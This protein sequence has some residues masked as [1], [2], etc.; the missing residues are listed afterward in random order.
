MQRARWRCLDS[1]EIES[2]GSS[3][4]L[5]A[6]LIDGV[7]IGEHCSVVALGIGALNTE[8]GHRRFGGEDPEGRQWYFAEEIRKPSSRALRRR[9]A[10][11]ADRQRSAP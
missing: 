1:V 8:Y 4:L 6:L 2:G 9:R 11:A 3:L 7:H 5:V 10:G